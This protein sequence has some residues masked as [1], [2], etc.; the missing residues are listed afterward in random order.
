MPA[1]S[2]RTWWAKP[3]VPNAPHIAHRWRTDGDLVQSL[4][5]HALRRASIPPRATPHVGTLTCSVCSAE[6]GAS[7]HFPWP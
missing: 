1:G 5:G 7:P 6:P 3:R 4:C 2:R